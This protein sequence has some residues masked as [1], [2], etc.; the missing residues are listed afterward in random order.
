LPPD[1]RP[2]AHLG[3]EVVVVSHADSL[4]EAQPTATIMLLTMGAS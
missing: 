3:L 4:I 1:H 2:D